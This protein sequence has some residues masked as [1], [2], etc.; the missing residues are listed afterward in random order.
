MCEW[1]P[2]D[3]KAELIE[4]CEDRGIEADKSMLKA[5]II[6]L[7]EADDAALV[8]EEEEPTVETVSPPIAP[9][10]ALGDVQRRT[11]PTLVPVSHAKK[12]VERVTSTFSVLDYLKAVGERVLYKQIIEAYGHGAKEELKALVATGMVAQYKQHN[13][14]W[15]KAN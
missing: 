10:A 5:N 6:A 8:D 11:I 13:T 1:S 3:T 2:H 14:F 15:F 9:L 7:L 4:V 12:P